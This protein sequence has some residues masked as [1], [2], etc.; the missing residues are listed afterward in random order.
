[1]S[2]Q[3]VW[4]LLREVCTCSITL[5]RFRPVREKKDNNEGESTE[6]EHESIPPTSSLLPHL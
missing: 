2:T 4:R 6:V 5:S 3:E 1:M